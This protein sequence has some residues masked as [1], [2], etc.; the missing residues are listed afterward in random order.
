MKGDKGDKG[1]QGP[2]GCPGP[3]GPA[4]E[5]CECSRLRVV[6]CNSTLTNDDQVVVI[7]SKVPVCITLPKLNGCHPTPGQCI[8]TKKLIITA[9][10]GSVSQKLVPACSNTINFDCNHFMLKPHT[11]ATL[12]TAGNTWIVT[13]H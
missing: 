1:D 6:E 10:C 4:C 13:S 8:M 11:S 3:Q 7:K 2:Q 12:Y 5:S 9:P